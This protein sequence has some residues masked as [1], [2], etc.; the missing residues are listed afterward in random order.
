MDL[1]VVVHMTVS[2]T[3]IWY[4]DVCKN[5]S[6]CWLNIFRFLFAIS[7]HI[8]FNGDNDILTRR[9]L[10]AKSHDAFRQTIAC[11]AFDFKWIKQAYDNNNINILRYYFTNIFFLTILSS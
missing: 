2:N 3:D 5:E 4:I 11:T 6:K 7:D 9:R 10:V 8:V 1:I